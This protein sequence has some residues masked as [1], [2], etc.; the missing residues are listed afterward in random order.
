[1][2]APLTFVT[3]AF[4][5]HPKAF[6]FLTF[7]SVVLVA[8]KIRKH[9]GFPLPPSPPSEPIIGN[10][11]VMPTEFQWKTFAEWGKKLG[12]V[13]YV[14]IIGKPIIVLNSAEAA[15]DLFDKRA[16]NYSDRPRFILHGELYGTEKLMPFITYGDRFRAQRRLMQQYFNSQAITSFIPLQTSQLRIFLQNLVQSPERFRQ[17]MH[18][19]TAGTLVMAT[20]G[21]E[22]TS[23]N[24]VI[25]KLAVDSAIRFIEGG[26]PGAT[27]VDFIPIL[28][29]LP[30][31]FPGAS[32]QKRAYYARRAQEDA[33][34]VPYK[35]VQ[36]RRAAGE[37]VPS[38]LSKM[39][40]VYE[41]KY[42]GDEDFEIN[43]KHV[44][45]V[46]YSAGVETSEIV[47]STFL[48]MMACHP[49]VVK[50]AQAEIDQVIGT[51][52]LPTHDD[53]PNLPYLECILKEIYR[54]NP[55]L[56]MGVAHSSITD[57]VYGGSRIP[58]NAMI[59]PNIWHMMR[60]ERHFPD[61]ES[62]KP[63]RFLSKVVQGIE[64]QNETG[65]DSHG[66]TGMSV[67]DPSSL[68]FGFGRRAC[69]GR[70][71]ADTNAWLTIANVLAVFDV[72]AAVDPVTGKEQKPV[73]DFMT[74]FASQPV[75]FKCDI[76]PRSA[77]HVEL[78]N[79]ELPNMY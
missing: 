4:D 47:L 32:F 38:L 15:R 40:D 26:T 49:E 34:D 70:F 2:N 66:L 9:V 37:A 72:R 6:V 8:H 76:V 62:F 29:Y 77:K 12:D 1:M 39:L 30:A 54:T 46:I 42:L 7:C 17:H 27:I 36:D 51:D 23:E 45:S 3:S 48:L 74:G 69:P 14:S 78:V 16:A 18:R 55:P 79:Q 65:R 61:P 33:R 25:T 11:R 68:V 67:D 41:N 71:F 73:V 53:R 56:P 60:D 13:I 57:D 10:L 63:E 43:M 28:R 59:I 75:P 22:V 21:H 19:F 24:D 58:A 35:E 50:R 44:A 64:T 5:R 31:W 52:R 20:Y